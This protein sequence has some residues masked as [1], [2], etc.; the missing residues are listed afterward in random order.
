VNDL[1]LWLAALVA[2]VT[3]LGWF[4]SRGAHWTIRFFIATL[5]A[6]TTIWAVACI[7]RPAPT[8]LELEG[9]RPDVGEGEGYSSSDACRA[10]HPGQY[11]SWHDS[12]HRTMTQAATPEAVVAPFDGRILE[13]RGTAFRVFEQ[14][15]GFY[16]LHVD[17]T[18]YDPIPDAVPRRVVLTTGS[19]H[20]QAYWVATDEGSL[21]QLPF[22]WFI[23]EERWLAND[24]SFLQG[25]YG[26]GDPLDHYVWGDGCVTCHTTGGPWKPEDIEREMFTKMAVTELGIACERCHGPADEH[27]RVNASPTRRYALH[28]ND[29]ADPT[30][31]NPR[32]LDAARSA[33]I[34]GTCHTVADGRTDAPPEDFAPGALLSDHLDYD[35]MAELAART[36]EVRDV[37]EIEN[38]EERDM[39]ESFWTNGVTRVAGREYDAMIRSGCYLDGEMSCITCHTMH[40][41]ATEE[42]LPP[43]ADDDRLCGGTCHADIVRDVEAHSHHPAESDGAQC[44]NCH[45]PYTSYGLLSAT[46][47]HRLDSPVASGFEGR[48]APN[49]CNLCHLDQSLGWTAEYLEQWYG[50]EAGELPERLKD[51]PAAALWMIR[52]DAVQRV[53]AGWHAGWEPAREASDMDSLRPAIA[54]LAVDDYSAVRQVAGRTIRTLDPSI[55]VDMHA[56]T[57]D[58][59]PALSRAVGRTNEII[60]EEMISWLFRERDRT[61]VAV[62]E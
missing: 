48:D 2:V 49:A 37:W 26:D 40:A 57:R 62:P 59:Q 1:A 9:A 14:G 54:I 33:S 10:C 31:V 47:S 29:E 5:F 42:Q 61:V 8:D 28:A 23:H 30:I 21:V 3:V 38:A 4:L 19:H 58:D 43:G 53:L 16:V 18:S 11:Q 50:I 32:R 12:F 39:V 13:E 17:A 20:V 45:M 36:S 6:T 22:V 25:P 60:D 7:G 55:E 35:G 46:R 56:L 52:G 51:V 41:E 27:V 44:V 15:D 24:D 34:C